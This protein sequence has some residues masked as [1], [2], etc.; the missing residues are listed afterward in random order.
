MAG[1]AGMGSEL[2]KYKAACRA[3][4]EAKSVDEA[5]DI[6]D[7]AIAVQAYAKQADNP[8][9][10]ADAFEIRKRAE[11]KAAELLKEM[12]E[13]GERQ[14]AGEA[15]GR[16]R[17]P[18]TPTLSDLG[19][20]RS[21]SSRWQQ[22]HALSPEEKAEII[23]K[24][25]KQIMRSAER[26]AASK[27]TRKTKHKKIAAKATLQLSHYGPFPL[28][29]ADPPWKWGHFGELD[30]ENEAGKGRTPDQHYPT[31]T[32]DEIKDFRVSGKLISEIA[33]RD[34]ALFLWCTSANI[35]VALE[36]IKAWGFTYKAHAVWVKDKSGLGLV[37]RNKHEPLL[38]ATRGN[39]P[40]P[41]Y[42]PP[43]VFAYPRGRHSAKPPEIRAEIEKMY[44]DFSAS[45][46]LELFARE[47]V[48]GWTCHG[49]ESDSQRAA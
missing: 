19:I 45:T 29:Y 12:A 38:Y 41:Q 2:I 18:S 31:L 6:R 23:S 28:I 30:N 33:H 4:A 43:S 32:Y 8:Q 47:T 15:D 27:A 25:R 20:S 13:R 11:D 39:M 26:A 49:F 16:A 21:Q 3:L 36:V 40:G 10:E 24:G 1:E 22:F 46:R 5:K 44:P 42:Q 34:A 14:K 35:E 7:K 17:R 9:L 48:E 37:F